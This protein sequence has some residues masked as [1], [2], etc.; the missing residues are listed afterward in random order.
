[1]TIVEFLEARLAED[2]AVAVA[3]T[4]AHWYASSGGDFQDVNVSGVDMWGGSEQFEP[5]GD[6]RDNQGIA[7]I[8]RHDPARVLREVAA[9]RELVAREG[10]DR[11]QGHPKPWMRHGE[12]GA[13]FCF[14]PPEGSVLYVLASAYSDHPDFNPDWT[15]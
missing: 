11:C 15:T 14:T 12:Y 7:H 13:G 3:A 5:L 10:S 8:Q 9:K 1:M 2:E 4:K 6:W